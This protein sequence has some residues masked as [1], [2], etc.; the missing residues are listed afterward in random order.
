MGASSARTQELED[1]VESHERAVGDLTAKLE[2]TAQA[3]E[4]TK[5]TAATS[6]TEAAASHA[7]AVD[8]LTKSH[9]A[10]VEEMKQKALGIEV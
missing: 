2:E 3:L 8:D 10:V 7:A 4:D 9:A 1:Q 5:A 6:A